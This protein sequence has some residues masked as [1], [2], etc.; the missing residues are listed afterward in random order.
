[1]ADNN[2][3]KGSKPDF[4]DMDKDGDRKEPM[5]KALSDKKNMNKDKIPEEYMEDGHEDEIN[6]TSALDTLRPGGGSNGTQSRA[7]MMATF[8]SLLSQLGVEDLTYLHDQALALIGHEAD[9]IPN[10][11]ADQNRATIMTKT[12]PMKE[13]IEEMFRGNDLTEE[14]KERASVIF[15]AVV[16]TRVAVERARLEEE[17]E[18]AVA[19]LEEEFT[20]KLESNSERDRHT[21]MEN[22]DQYLNYVVEQWVEENKIAIESGLRSQIAE[23]FISGLHRL[24]T[25]H[26]ITV[27]EQKVDLVAEMKSEI[28]DLRS[29]L[30][31]ALD[32]N[33]QLSSQ[34]NE[35]TKETLIDEMASNLSVVQAEKLRTLAEGIDYSGD[36]DAYRRKLGI[37]KENYFTSKGATTG[38]ITE[39]IDG[40]S[41]EPEVVN[42]GMAKYVSAI[43]KSIRS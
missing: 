5:K 34:V 12:A 19:S 26:Y 36:I 39:S 33:I 6:E 16:N 17:F 11:A 9:Q 7:D 22:I 13:E 15:E 40:D 38:L 29:K 8:A 23:D 27:P 20:A 32:A 3:S 28:T 42:A 14:F 35:S 21:M 10:G 2:A 18:D 41:G 24:F 43:S 4:L 37:L 1:M 30:N 25:E 31:E